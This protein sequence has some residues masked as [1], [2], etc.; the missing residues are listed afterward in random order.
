MKTVEHGSPNTAF[1]GVLHRN[2]NKGGERYLKSRSYQLYANKIEALV[3][4][5]VV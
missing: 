5:V 2:I 4:V 3:D 1:G